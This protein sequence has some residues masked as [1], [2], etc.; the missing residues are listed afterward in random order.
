MYANFKYP[1]KYGFH[2]EFYIFIINFPFYEFLIIFH[3]SA[4]CSEEY[5]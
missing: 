4:V 1:N 3:E 2:K 5:V